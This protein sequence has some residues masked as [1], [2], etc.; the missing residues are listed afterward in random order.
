MKR[1]RGIDCKMESY[2]RNTFTLLAS[3]NHY[4]AQA[5]FCQA[6]KTRRN[7]YLIQKDLKIHN[8]FHTQL[9]PIR[10]HTV[11]TKFCIIKAIAKRECDECD[12]ETDFMRST[13]KK[14][15]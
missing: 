5:F 14:L 1:Y 7:V 11:E 15:K 9:N 10:R 6:R 4:K 12:D 13:T 8:N 3:N 2:L